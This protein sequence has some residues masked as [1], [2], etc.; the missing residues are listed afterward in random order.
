[1]IQLLQQFGAVLVLNR[2]AGRAGGF[3]GVQGLMVPIEQI[4]LRG[5]FDIGHMDLN[6][7]LLPDPVQAAD[8]LF[9]QIRMGG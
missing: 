5:I 6:A 4:L 7:L 2:V 3:K 1:M 8:P 9:Q